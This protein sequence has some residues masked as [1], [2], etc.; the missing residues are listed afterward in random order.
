[1]NVKIGLF[2]FV[3]MIVSCKPVDYLTVNNVK[4]VHNLDNASFIY[5]LPQTSFRISVEIV[6]T[7]YKKGP[8]SDY[9]DEFLGI[10]EII[11]KDNV[12][13]AI[14]G[15]TVESFSDIDPAQ[16]YVVKKGEGNFPLDQIFSLSEN[17]LIV[18][19]FPLMHEQYNNRVNNVNVEDK[20]VFKDLTVNRNLVEKVDTSYRTVFRD[21]SFVQVPIFKKQMV[22]KS[23]RENAE[24]AAHFIIKTRK[25]RFKLLAGQYDV[26]PQGKALEIS[27]E[28]LNKTESEY[29]SL[30]IGKRY[31]ESQIT[32]FYYTPSKTDEESSLVL[33]KFSNESGLHDV[34]FMGGSSVTLN[35]KSL[36][37]TITLQ[38]FGVTH[39]EDI[40]NQ[41]YYRL[42]EVV[43][44]TLEKENKVLAEGRFNVYQLGELIALPVDMF[45]NKKE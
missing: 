29:L 40:H 19:S 35:L 18:S 17:G 15:I 26:F 16:Y 44:L 43:H 34:K 5:S 7:T 9:A 38:K 27:V 13:Y 33:F 10:K 32:E 42:P 22:A 23:I 30:F 41:I 8:Y 39:S 24:E 31:S 20:L 4:E 45:L 2:L 12:S 6:K 25:R 14:A 21:S 1:M 36:D 11:E 28:E 37:K 3:L